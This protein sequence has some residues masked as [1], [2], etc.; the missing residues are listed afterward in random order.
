MRRA[1]KVDFAGSSGPLSGVIDQPLDRPPRGWML[2]AHGF[3]SSKQFRPLAR[4]ARSLA[5]RGWGVL[6]FD[7]AGHGASAG[8]FV[9]GGFAG[10][11]A[12][13][14]AASRF[15]REVQGAAAQLWIGH[16]LGGAAM[17]ACAADCRDL[18]G[19]ATIAAPA[20][21]QHLAAALLALEPALADGDVQLPIAGVQRQITRRLLLEL[22]EFDLAAA[23]A[24]IAVPLLLLH[25]A[26]DELVSLEHARRIRELRGLAAEVREIPDADHLLNDERQIEQVASWIGQWAHPLWPDARG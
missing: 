1:S 2:L 6:R 15:L 11:R 21:T 26:Q 18:K 7:F 13:V 9:A 25:G 4:I 19:L 8:P 20:D 17:L 24:R 12:D 23:I 16:S 3:G 5:R 10:L 14:Q 22:Q